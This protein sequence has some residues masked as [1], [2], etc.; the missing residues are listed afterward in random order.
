M[1]SENGTALRE[2]VEAA[3]DD[4]RPGIRAD[5]GDV[6][7]IKIEDATAYVQMVGACGGCAMVERDAQTRDRA[8]RDRRLSRNRPR[9]ANLNAGLIAWLAVCAA[10]VALSLRSISV[11][12]ARS[13][14]TAVGWWFTLAYFVFAGYS[15][16]VRAHLP[17]VPEYWSLGALTLAF[18]VAGVKDEPQSEPWWWPNRASTTRRERRAAP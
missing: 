12:D 5:G 17:F 14:W 3:L 10:G 6:W 2:R 16:I 9:G 8:A 7:L 13:R 1:V 11:L 4:V 18:V 15:A